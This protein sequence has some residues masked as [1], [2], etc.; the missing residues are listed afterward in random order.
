LEKADVQ[1]IWSAVYTEDWNAVVIDGNFLAKFPDPFH[2]C[3][4]H[5]VR[6]LAKWAQRK[7][8]GELVAPMFARQEQ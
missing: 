7:A 3:F 4:E 2:L 8:N 5:V 6:Q 1:P